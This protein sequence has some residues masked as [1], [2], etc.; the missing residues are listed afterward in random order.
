MALPVGAT[1]RHVQPQSVNSMLQADRWMVTAAS[2]QATI[3]SARAV[4]NWRSKSV[5]GI[6]RPKQ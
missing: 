6:G 5:A 1:V 3:A 4:T 2:R